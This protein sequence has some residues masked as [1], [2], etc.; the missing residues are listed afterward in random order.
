MSTEVE[1]NVNSQASVAPV[2]TPSKKEKKKGPEKTDEFLLARFKG[3]GVRYKAKLIGVDDVPE[4]RGDKMSQD[5][6]MKLKGMSVASRSQGKHKQKVWINISLSGIKVI[7]EKTGVIEH[8][9]PVN[10]ISFIARDVTDSRA[11]GYVCGAEGQHQFF[12]IKTAQQAEPLVVDLK[13]LFQLIFNMK[14]KEAEDTNKNGGNTSLTSESQGDKFKRDGQLDLFGDM[15]TPPDLHSPSESKDILLLDL[16]TDIDSSQNC[17]KGNP[18][19]ASCSSVPWPRP[20]TS[21]SPEKPFSSQLNFFPAPA[22]DPFSDD[23]FS[24]SNDQPT[25]ADPV[26][27]PPLD[28]ATQGKPSHIFS[29][30]KVNGGQNG[31]S[32]YLARQFDQLSN[33]T[34]IQ[35][36]SNGQ[37][38]LEGKV[39]DATDWTQNGLPVREQN[40]LHYRSPQNPFFDTCAKNAP[41]HNP[42]MPESVG[43]VE[44]PCPPAKDSVIISPPPLNTKAGRGRRGIKSP[45][46]NQF[47]PD[48]FTS[49]SQKESAP[50]QPDPA[51]TSPIGVFSTVPAN[52]TSPVTAMGALSLGTPTTAPSLATA[53]WRPPAPPIFPAPNGVS[54][55][56]ASNAQPMSS[57]QPLAFSASPAP[58][59]GQAPTAFGVP[60]WSQAAPPTAAAPW[61]QPSALANPFQTNVFPVASGPSSPPPQPPPRPA[62]LKEAPRVE[63]TAFLSLDPLS[64]QKQKSTKDMFKDFQ[65]AKPPV[66]PAR[67][68][69]PNPATLFTPASG[70]PN[71]PTAPVL[72]ALAPEATHFGSP[73]SS[74]QFGAVPPAKVAPPVQPAVPGTFADPFGNLFA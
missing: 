63:T 8:E 1:T 61:P 31:D 70:A 4:A 52:T 6:M 58:S 15:S 69:T 34:V 13:D 73:F 42:T 71:A 18:F 32:D 67:R 25:R 10:K 33:R 50:P 3:D 28:S 16:S 64:E 2:K 20:Q 56:A 7:D 17:V 23:P 12:A 29:S 39:A 5:S 19:T 57:S 36:L 40:G 68:E 26:I 37:W 47:G 22:A 30:P 62:P 59:W 65:L 46:G 11:F 24:K 49:S 72:A 60:T 41:L 21:V 55:T 38:P 14:K 35:S 9:H 27:S 43:K 44:P 45:T 66:V 53:P 54:V 74:D 48:L 51:Q